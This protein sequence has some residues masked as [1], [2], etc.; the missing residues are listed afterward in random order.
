MYLTVNGIAAVTDTGNEL[1]QTKLELI[2]TGKKN[3]L[4]TKSGEC[5]PSVAGCGTA[6][7]FI[8]SRRKWG[9]AKEL[10]CLCLTCWNTWTPTLR[11]AQQQ[12]HVRASLTQRARLRGDPADAC[13]LHALGLHVV[14]LQKVWDHSVDVCLGH[15]F[16]QH[17]HAQTQSTGISS[18][19]GVSKQDIKGPH[20]I[21]GDPDFTGWRAEAQNRNK[22]WLLSLQI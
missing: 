22:S 17:L 1:L 3:I 11:R 21:S 4:R 20:V 7:V 2:R 9:D 12:E 18:T 16:T 8:S 10:S 13:V 19:A 5:L 6:C 15:V 14:E